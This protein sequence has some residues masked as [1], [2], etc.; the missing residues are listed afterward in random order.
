[1]NSRVS[2]CLFLIFI[3]IGV[4]SL[5]TI[6]DASWDSYIETPALDEEVYKKLWGFNWSS[7]LSIVE[8]G[9]EDVF[10]KGKTIRVVHISFPLLPKMKDCMIH[11][12]IYDSGV[13][14]NAWIILVHGLGGTHKFFEEEL[15][16]YKLSYE[17]AVRG[18]KVLSIDAAG[19]GLSCIPGG[20]SWKDKALSIE[21]GDFFLYYVYVSGVRA[22]EVAKALGAEPG[23]IAISGVSMGGL[24]SYVVASIHPDVT[25]AVPIVA[26]GCLSCMIQSGG[27]ANLVGPASTGVTSDVVEKLAASDPLAYIKYSGEKGGLRDKLFYIA[28][29]GHDE[30]FPIE[31]LVL[32]LKALEEGGAG[33]YVAFDGNNNH[34]KPAPGWIP[35]ILR[36]LE[37][38]RDEGIDGVKRLMPDRGGE[39]NLQS[40]LAGSREWRPAADGLA[41]IPSIP[42]TPLLAGE[43]VVEVQEN[44]LVTSL[45]KPEPFILRLAVFIAA[46]LIA[47][48]LGVRTGFSMMKSSTAI[49]MAYLTAALFTAS[50]WIWPGRF[51]LGITSLME[52]YAVT[53]SLTINV[54][55][56]QIMTLSVLIA[57]LLASL[58]ITAGRRATLAVY[59]IIFLALSITPFIFMRII[60]STIENNALQPIPARITP[61]ELGPI[62]ILIIAILAR[63]RLK[64]RHQAS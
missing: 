6:L 58:I 30:Y 20:K 24:T 27:L 64:P 19:H 18:F 54:P 45:P 3:I 56:S 12:F 23:K 38:F 59:S 31:G 43:V 46:T 57:P 5:L 55:S 32:T 49:A 35:S 28:F 26:S 53:P 37:T 7:G 2:Y 22:V 39:V 33:V 50:Y 17:L 60:I 62:I 11:G 4:S 16:G 1:M 44:P 47:A 48:L 41:Y 10:Y 51:A 15:D 61:I 14:G 52:R 29:S 36:I 13:Q 21:P 34:Y 9:S 63:R 25:L 8:M 42:L 40:F